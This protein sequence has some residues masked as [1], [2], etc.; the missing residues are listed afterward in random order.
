MLVLLV[1]LSACGLRLDTPPPPVPTPGPTESARAEFVSATQDLIEQARSAAQRAE[2]DLAAELNAL[3][4]ASQ[5]H[6]EAMG[7]TWTPPP[8]PSSPGSATPSSSPG[9]ATPSGNSST[10]PQA[11]AEDVLGT[12]TDLTEN[13]EVLAQDIWSGQ[14]ATLIA[15][16]TVY[17]DGARHRL[18][19]EL[20]QNDEPAGEPAQLPQDLGSAATEL[21]RTLDGL[22]YA[23]EVRAARSNG[24]HRTEA[25]QRAEGYRTLARQVAEAAGLAGTE[26]DPRSASYDIGTD[27]AETITSWQAELVPAWLA[28][29]GDAQ[30][31]DR[32]VL[33][34][35][36]QEAAVRAGLPAD[37]AFPGLR[38]S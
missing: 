7:G 4:E 19:A 29:I 3:A 12:L 16:I 24:D 6:L 20:D 26:S 23:Y 2:G 33:L 11:T 13:S 18:R 27:L 35:H 31:Q 15:S 38:Q 37:T 5:E 21:C 9:N 28:L 34:S 36:A 8:R 22:G 1:T 25:A 32:P 10:Q 14:T 30:P 17:R